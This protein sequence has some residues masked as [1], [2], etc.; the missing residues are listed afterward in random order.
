MR[1]VWRRLVR[2]FASLA[3]RDGGAAAVEF[4][5]I[6]PIMIFIYVGCVEA[7]ALI[8][9][10]RRVQTVS[11][12][13]GDLVARSDKTITSVTLTDY[14]RAS[15]GVMTP[16]PSDDL[17]QIVTEVFVDSTGTAKVVWSR[18]YKN[19]LY[20]IG[21]DYVKDEVFPLPVEMKDI[22]RNKWVIVAQASYDYL[23]LY[24]IVFEQS[25]GLNRA[26]FFMP[27]FGSSITVN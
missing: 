24:G 25:V 5:L 3:R 19:E 20:A 18:E 14:F 16:Y 23:P 26:S 13:L 10:D 21:T 12:T 6:L 2:Q 9:M 8:S 22:A 17:E 1:C 7:S 4:A 15:A 27:R 11:G